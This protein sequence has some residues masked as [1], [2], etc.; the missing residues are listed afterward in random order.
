MI[1]HGISFRL[2]D[3]DPRPGNPI[4]EVFLDDRYIGSII[5][6]GSLPGLRIASQCIDT[7]NVVMSTVASPVILIP[8]VP[9]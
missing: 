9:R 6:D 7:G 8:L 1:E 2:G 3:Q 4:V 5:A